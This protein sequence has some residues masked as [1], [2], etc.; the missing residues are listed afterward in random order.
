VSHQFGHNWNLSVTPFWTRG[1]GY[2]EEYKVGQAFADYGISGGPIYRPQAGGGVDTIT[3]TDVIRRRWLKTDLY[4]ATYSLQYRPESGRLTEVT[5]GGAAVGYR[6]Q[7]FDDLQWAQLGMNIPEPG[8]RYYQEP[9]SRKTDV[10]GYARATLQLTDPLSAFVDLQYRHV[11]YEFY[12]PNSD[13]TKQ[14]Q[15]V[16]FNFFNPKAGLTYALPHDLTLYASYA[17]AHREPTRTD[18]TDVPASRRPAAEQL[19]NLE[20]GIRRQVGRWQWSV[21]YYLMRYRDQLVLSGQLDDVGNAIHTNVRRSYRTGIELT[22][23]AQLLPNFTWSPNL[24]LSRNRIQNYSDYLTNYDTNSDQV[25]QYRETDISFS[26]AVVGG[27]TF[28][29]EPVKGLRVALL[30]KYV[31]RQYLDN[32]STKARSL[33]PYF[34]NDVRLR[35]RWVPAE[36]VLG[37]RSV[38]AAL[39]LNNILSEKYE[40]N[41]FT[42]GYIS[43]GKAEYFNFYFPQAPRNFLAS[44]TLSF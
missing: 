33:D 22:A 43:G 35:Y 9:N 4:G 42:Y 36:R 5:L 37:M 28:E 40:N 1:G 31:S 30:S 16:D 7:H 6:G 8:T 21:N 19:H 13:S 27:N 29:Y 10:N 39:L 14:Q 2:Y 25:T 41:G 44:L 32:T 18:Y 3:T 38:E 20:A 11:L 26:P 12:G 15:Q 17:V 34:V 24:T 23:A